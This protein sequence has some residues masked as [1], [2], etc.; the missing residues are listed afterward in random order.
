MNAAE[1]FTMKG[2]HQ[3]IVAAY[4][5]ENFVFIGKPH[6]AEIQ[7]PINDGNSYLVGN[8]Y[9]CALDADDFI[10]DNL[11]STS[12]VLYFIYLMKPMQDMVFTRCQEELEQPIIMIFWKLAPKGQVVM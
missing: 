12:G 7:L 5:K 11:D 6:N 2:S 10:L 9:P 1:G 8:P 3:P 4:D